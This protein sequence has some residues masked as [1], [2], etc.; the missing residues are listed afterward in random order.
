MAGRHRKSDHV[1]LTRVP[2][3]IPGKPYRQTASDLEN[4]KPVSRLRLPGY[5]PPLRLTV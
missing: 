1:G 4:A 3:I 5:L 2:I